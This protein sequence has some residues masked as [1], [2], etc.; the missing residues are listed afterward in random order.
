MSAVKVA[1]ITATA[2]AAVVVTAN[3][4]YQRHKRKQF[5]KQLDAAFQNLFGGMFGVDPTEKGSK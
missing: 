2:T 1:V 4:L 5:E 3:A